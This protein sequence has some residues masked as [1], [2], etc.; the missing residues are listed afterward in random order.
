MMNRFLGKLYR[1]RQ[2]LVLYYTEMV[3]GVRVFL[4]YPFQQPNR[5]L[6]IFLA[7]LQSST[8]ILVTS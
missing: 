2:A 1:I 3:S 8:R 6:R 7:F 4:N 5:I